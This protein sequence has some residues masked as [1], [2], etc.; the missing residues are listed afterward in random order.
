VSGGDARE[1][2][3][4]WCRNGR[5]ADF[6]AFYR[7]QAPRLWRFLRARGLDA[8]TAY[9][10]VAESFTRF[11][12][13]VCRD[14]AEPVALLYRIAINWRIDERRRAAARPTTALPEVDI[15]AA[16]E[17]PEHAALR[18]RVAALPPPEQNL[19][20]MRYWLGFSF[21]EIAA[22]T[23]QPEGTLRRQASELLRD[24]ARRWQGGV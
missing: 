10:G 2:I 7:Q 9:D 11:V 17:A 12:Q 20:L 16:A 19:L 14:P 6:D 4:R 24:L 1:H 22:M 8:D 3:R 23:G 15:A 5:A 21:R 18:E 13:A